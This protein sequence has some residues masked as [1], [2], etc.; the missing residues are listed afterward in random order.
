M[1]GL[2]ELAVDE[3]NDDMGWYILDTDNVELQIKQW[4]LDDQIKVSEVE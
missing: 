2:L 3:V 1:I 4:V